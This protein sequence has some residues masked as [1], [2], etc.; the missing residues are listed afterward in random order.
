MPCVSFAIAAR[1]PFE[2]ARIHLSY[3][4]AGITKNARSAESV[5]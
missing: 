3:L 2:L 5:H 1:R 4:L